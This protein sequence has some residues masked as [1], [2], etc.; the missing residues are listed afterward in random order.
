MLLGAVCQFLVDVL[1]IEVTI[2]FTIHFVHRRHHLMVAVHVFLAFV[3]LALDYIF[4][5]HQ[6]P[7]LI[8][9]ITNEFTISIGIH[10]VGHFKLNVFAFLQ[11]IE[12]RKCKGKAA[13][14]VRVVGQ[15]LVNQLFDLIVGGNVGIGR[16]IGIFVIPVL[17]FLRSRF[18]FS[19][20]RAIPVR[21]GKAP[22]QLVFSCTVGELH[23]C[24]L[25]LA[26]F[27]VSRYRPYTVGVRFTYALLTKLPGAVGLD[28]VIIGIAALKALIV[29]IEVVD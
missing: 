6:R 21:L 20:A 16:S 10:D 22:F 19:H 28:S 12:S 15:C 27:I 11:F 24:T 4:L 7:F 8:I 18:D 17:I 9:G 26:C 5:R 14:R 25:H 1:V 2:A 23:V 13:A 29:A 3:H